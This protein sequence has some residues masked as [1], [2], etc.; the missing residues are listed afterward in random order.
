M[1]A[2]PDMAREVALMVRR[3]YEAAEARVFERIV[4]AVTAGLDAPDWQVAQQGEYLAVLA[5]LDRYLQ[6]LD[7]RAPALFTEAVARAYAAGEEAARLDLTAAGIDHAPIGGPRASWA[8]Q[9]LA[10]DRAQA[11]AGMRPR[12]MRSV[13]DVYQQ[14]TAETAA[15]VL[16]GAMDRREAAR[17]AL[18]AYAD[19]SVTGFRDASGRRWDL[20]SYAE[21]TTRTTAGQAA[22]QG[23]TDQ[24]RDLGQDLVKVSKSPESCEACGRWQGRVLSLTGQTTGRLSDGVTVAGTITEARRAGL[25]HPNCFPGWVPVDSPTGVL[26]SDSRWFEGQVVVIH[27]AGGRELTVTPNHPVLTSE[28]WV[29]AGALCEG[30]DL[31]AHRAG[32]EGVAPGAPDHDRVPAPIGEVHEALGQSLHVASVF[33]PGAPEQFHGD[34]SSDAEVHVVRA[35]GLLRLNGKPESFEVTPEGEFLVR[36]VR[37]PSLLRAGASF[38]VAVR[39]GHPAD[40]GVSVRGEGG[41]FGGTHVGGPDLGGLS[42][43]PHGDARGREAAADRLPGDS[44]PFGYLLEG[45][46]GRVE[47]D[48]VVHVGR[49]EFAGHVYNLQTGGG[50]YVASD[51]IVHNC[52]HTVGLYLPGYS[53]RAEATPADPALYEV[54]QQ[55]RAQERAIR[56]AKRAVVIDAQTLGP[57]HPRTVQSRRV[58]RDRQAAHRQWREAHGRKDLAY[59]RSTV[60]R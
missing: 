6:G 15:Q 12:I 59:R 45:L 21:M 57:T 13:R 23:H 26:A 20:A 54:R 19:R 36:G 60:A 53:K 1:P 27:T 31:I 40:G 42:T 11:L 28:G 7:E 2:S 43:A 5:E 35:D 47:A 44:E 10:E 24:L 52:T 30:H 49:R 56:R 17:A 46:A 39:A 25:Q 18:R 29:P 16:T 34:G 8:V 32:V 48:R 50:W 37:Q 58:L 9:A 41:P 55:Q 4:A 22:I 3:I 51:L 38:E 33:V 14:V